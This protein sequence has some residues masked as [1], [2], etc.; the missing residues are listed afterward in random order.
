M[1]RAC[2][3]RDDV[4]CCHLPF[5]LPYLVHRRPVLFDCVGRASRGRAGR[6]HDGVRRLGAAEASPANQKD[7]DLVLKQWRVSFGVSGD[8]GGDHEETLPLVED[9]FDRRGRLQIARR[10]DEVGQHLRVLFAMENLKQSS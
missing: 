5:F 9:R 7:G 8:R 6:L 3:K 4:T 2:P 10:G 1:T